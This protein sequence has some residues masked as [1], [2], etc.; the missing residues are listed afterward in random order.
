MVRTNYSSY[1]WISEFLYLPLEFPDC[2]SGQNVGRLVNLSRLILFRNYPGNAEIII[3][4]FVSHR[5]CVWVS[6]ISFSKRDSLLD[7]QDSF[8][9]W[10]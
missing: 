5:S 8:L 1:V 9:S 6:N 10:A 4:F 2:F 7:L 3:D